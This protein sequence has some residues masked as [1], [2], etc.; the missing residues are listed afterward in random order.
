MGGRGFY[1]ICFSSE[2]VYFQQ[3]SIMQQFREHIYVSEK[4]YVY[5]V[6]Q[7]KGNPTLAC[8][9][10]LITGCMNVIFAYSHKDQGLCY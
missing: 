6:S 7:K 3:S 4:V 2:I 1:S 8:H 5:R 9:R 10:A